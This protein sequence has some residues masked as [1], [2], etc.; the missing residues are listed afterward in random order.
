MKTVIKTV[1]AGI[2]C[3][4]IG[5]SSSNSG[6]SVSTSLVMTGSGQASTIAKYKVQHPWLSMFLPSA[7]AFP[8]PAMTD[9]TG[10]V[11]SMTKSWIVIKEIEFKAD[12]TA[13]AEESSSSSEAEF[14][15]PYVVDLLSSTPAPLGIA[16]VPAGN[17][18]RIKMKLEKAAT[19]PADAP[20]GLNGNSMYF[21]ATVAGN[22]ITF[23]S[24]DGSEFQ[25]GGAH[26]VDISSDAGL[27]VSIKIA[28]LFK[29]IDLSGVNS[30]I[31][32]SSSNRVA[33]VN[34]C[35][36]IEP[37]AQDLYTCFRK[38]F[39]K[40]GKFGKDSNGD[41]EMETSEDEVHQ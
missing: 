18:R 11:V 36:L 27:L 16:D 20:A 10:L 23:S 8:P 12:E 32:I 29:M 34:K 9:S 13:G 19:L 30:N 15:G 31:A 6:Q 2:A 1:V 3:L 4:S 38:G 14:K 41:H 35:P 7:V 28:D 17:Y 5:C 33:A 24:D 21:E 37:S 40:A 26:G 25:I 39:E 22:Q